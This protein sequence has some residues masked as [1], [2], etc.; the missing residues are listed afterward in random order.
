MSTLWITITA[1]ST[2]TNQVPI[3][4]VA[5][6]IQKYTPTDEPARSALYTVRKDIGLQGIPKKNI[7]GL[8]RDLINRS[9]SLS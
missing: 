4:P 3:T 6:P 1:S 8:K 7:I 9:T 2:R 5:T